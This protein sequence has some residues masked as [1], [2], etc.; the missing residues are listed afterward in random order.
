MYTT[1]IRNITGRDRMVRIRNYICLQTFSKRN[2]YKGLGRMDWIKV[3][4][5]CV[6]NHSRIFVQIDHPYTVLLILNIL[7]LTVS[8]V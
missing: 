4:R 3:L 7:L 1:F 2:N 6:L 8:V 5:K